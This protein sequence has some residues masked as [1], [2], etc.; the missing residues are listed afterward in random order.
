MGA[1]RIDNGGDFT[2]VLVAGGIV[3]V[4]LDSPLPTVELDLKPTTDCE[5]GAGFVSKVRPCGGKWGRFATPADCCKAL[6]ISAA[7]R[8]GFNE[9][10]SCTDARRF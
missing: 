5:A 2:V 9:P 8:L 3:V 1:D 7:A 4:A 6:V 10:N